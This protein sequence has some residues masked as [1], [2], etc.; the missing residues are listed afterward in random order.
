[1][2]VYRRLASVALRDAC[3]FEPTC[4]EYALHAIRRYRPFRG[5]MKALRRIARCRQSN[6][7]IDEP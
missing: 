7:G 4:S 3:F 6:G 2:G 5:W 1:M